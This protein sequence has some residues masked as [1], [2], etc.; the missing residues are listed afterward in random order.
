MTYPSKKSRVFP[1]SLLA[2][3]VAGP[4]TAFEV[5]VG[6]TKASLYGY[7]KLDIIHDLDADLGNFVDR[8]KIRLDGEK[9]PDGHTTLHAFQSRL[10]VS[11]ATP[12]QMGELKTTLEG[13]FYGSGG[14]NLRLRHAYGEWNGITAGQTWSN[15]GGHLAMYPTIDFAPWPGMANASRQAQLRYTLQGFSV[16][17]EDPDNLGRQVSVTPP[18]E[19][20]SGLPDLTLRYQGQIAALD[21]GAS[22]MLRQLEYYRDATDSDETA[23]GWGLNLEARYQ[24]GD[25]TLRGALTHGDGI[26]GYLEGSPARPG[27]VDPVSGELETIKA[28]GATAGIT[29][30]A[31]PGAATLGYG[32]ARSDIDDAVRAGATGFGGDTTEQFEAIHLNYIWSPAGQVSYGVEASHHT[33]R[34]QDGR[35]GD[36]T[37][38]QAMV[39]YRF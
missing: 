20:K 23:L 13:D 30:K 4:A 31:G 27:Y 8:N 6:D 21:Y 5:Q 18:D 35:D 28:T 26:G 39:M 22:V 7:A 34:V 17:L 36:A 3:L 1:L 19:N 14:G 24:L 2:L 10:G 11:T 32:I 12:T 29:V 16:A 15:F 38:L 9:G 25:V 33:R 37:R